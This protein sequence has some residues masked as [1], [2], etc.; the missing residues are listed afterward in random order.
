MKLYVKHLCS[1]GKYDLEPTRPVARW[2]NG[3]CHVTRALG[4]TLENPQKRFRFL[5]KRPPT[6]SSHPVLTGMFFL[7]RS[8]ERMIERQNCRGL[9]PGRGGIEEGCQP[10]T[11]EAFFC[12]QFLV[13]KKKNTIERTRT[14]DETGLRGMCSFLYREGFILC[15]GR[16]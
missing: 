6:F 9:V 15:V 1:K 3:S 4:D 7:G 12:F 5:A 2:Q 11:A 10:C 13:K 14:R 16:E 8:H